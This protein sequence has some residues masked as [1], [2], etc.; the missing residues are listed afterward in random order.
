MYHAY[1]H[2]VIKN[3]ELW[4]E[5]GVIS[6]V[7]L[8]V[9]DGHI[10]S[11]EKDLILTKGAHVINGN[12]W[13]LLPAGVD[14]QVHLR[15]PGQAEKETAGTGLLAALRG[16]I[17]AVLSMP[18]TKPTIDSIEVCEAAVLELEEAEHMT[19]VKAYLTGSITQAL[20][21][22]SP[23]PYEELAKW[24]VKAFT[25]DGLGVVDDDLMR[26]AFKASALT[27]LPIL[28]HAEFPGHGGVLAA[29]PMQEK[30]GIA[31]YPAAAE[32]DMVARDINI[33]RDYPKAH[34][35][36]LHV[37]AHE[38]LELVSTAKKQALNVTCEVTPHHLWFSSDDIVD[39]RT[40]FKMNPPLRG[41]ADRAALRH[42]LA[43]G[44]IDFVATDHAPHE[45]SAKG[46][47]FKTSAFGT[48]G[49]E[50]SLR[51]LLTLVR[52]GVLSPQRL[53]QVFS[54]KPA[55]FLGIDK[56]IGDIS[57]GR[58][59]AGVL[60]DR[61][62]A[63]IITEDDLYSLSKNSCFLGEKLDGKIQAVFLADRYYAF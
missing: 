5:R 52:E 1:S 55:Q 49:L 30:L 22:K 7:D 50:T 33:L 28:Q 56:D 15:V 8:E 59:M 29:G 51:V 14:P 44:T 6:S 53:V 46:A 38:T 43:D 20:K 17:G 60:V 37:S 21:G 26:S 63:S 58:P 2:Y 36:V 16:G 42:G 25:D 61:Q 19:G 3:V 9:I 34:Y 57:K 10:H 31:P 27:G 18:N 32:A 47:N 62:S 12:G 40:S 39:D 11:V 48:T 23:A 41:V 4:T 35:H 45:A 24:G 54:S 13:T